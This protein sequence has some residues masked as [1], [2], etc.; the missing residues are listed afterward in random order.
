MT[1]K[2]EELRHAARE[3]WEGLTSSV[4]P[5][6]SVGTATCGRSAGALVSMEIS[7]LTISRM[8]QRI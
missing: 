2:I 4:V 8:L 6:V 5:V 1:P 3:A 7:A